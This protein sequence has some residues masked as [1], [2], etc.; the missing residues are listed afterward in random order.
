M[1]GRPAGLQ[2]RYDVPRRVSANG[3]RIKC[4][5]I[6]SSFGMTARSPFPFFAVSVFG[7]F[8]IELFPRDRCLEEQPLAVFFCFLLRPMGST[9]LGDNARP[10]L[11]G[12]ILG[13]LV[14]VRVC[15]ICVFASEHSGEKMGST[16][17]QT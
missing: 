9:L 8:F 15:L 16:A 10:R 4:R 7:F 12:D 13:A 17:C 1:N 6:S 14:A 5:L 11:V 2:R 3:A